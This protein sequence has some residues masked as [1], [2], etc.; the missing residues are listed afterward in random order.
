MNS[1]TPTKRPYPLIMLVDDSA[2]DNFVN[3]KILKRYGFSD[4]IMAYTKTRNALRYLL[5]INPHTPYEEIP[6]FIFLDLNM[7]EID[8]FEFLATFALLSDKIKKQVRVVV[9]TS[10]INPMDVETC[11]KYDFVLTFLYKPLVKSNLDAIELMLTG[12]EGK[13]NQAIGA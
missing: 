1:T 12:E 2:I 10:S 6:S 3:S 8:G 4:N 5:K 7:P 13:F 11:H 9:L